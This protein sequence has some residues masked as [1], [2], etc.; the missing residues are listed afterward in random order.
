[1]TRL[2]WRKRSWWWKG[3]PPGIITA[4]ATQINMTEHLRGDSSEVSPVVVVVV[5]GKCSRVENSIETLTHNPLQNQLT[6]LTVLFDLIILNVLKYNTLAWVII[7]IA[8][9]LG[10][11]YSYPIA[12][13]RFLSIGGV[14]LNYVLSYWICVW[15]G[16]SGIYRTPRQTSTA[17]WLQWWYFYF[18]FL[19]LNYIL[20]FFALSSHYMQQNNVEFV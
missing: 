7:I 4:H 12:V 8:W 3:M 10:G 19:F 9:Q 16:E 17:A 11:V 18:I 13:L 5:D 1:M 20:H 14:E 15:M 6:M 2:T